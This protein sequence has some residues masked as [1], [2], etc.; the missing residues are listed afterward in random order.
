MDLNVILISAEM[1]SPRLFEGDGMTTAIL[2]K[3]TFLLLAMDLNVILII[4][5]MRSLRLPR[6]IRMTIGLGIRMTIG[7]AI[8]MV[9]VI[10]K[11]L[12]IATTKR[13]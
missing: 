5:V 8:M 3:R 1:R 6:E 7:L 2:I 9:M 10:V 11:P 12:T 4:A 13:M